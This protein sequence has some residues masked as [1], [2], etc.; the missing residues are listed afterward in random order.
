[1]APSQ[2]SIKTFGKLCEAMGKKNEVPVEKATDPVSE[3]DDEL[4][5]PHN[6][7][8]KAPAGRSKS[9]VSSPRRS[10]RSR[11]LGSGDGGGGGTSSWSS[12]RVPKEVIEIPSSP[13]ARSPPRA[14]LA[15]SQTTTLYVPRSSDTGLGYFKQFE[16]D[17]D[18]ADRMMAGRAEEVD[19]RRPGGRRMWRQSEVS[20]LDL[21]GED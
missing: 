19:E 1:M 11:M 21:T 2:A 6:L 9:M 15:D 16:V 14:V 3:S 18:T 8:S 5:E 12:P 17:R 4:E 13:P 10:S 20:I 7:G